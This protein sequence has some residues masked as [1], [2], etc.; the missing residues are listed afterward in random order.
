M[1][2]GGGAPE[3]E[4][5]HPVRLF[6]MRHAK[7]DQ[8]RLAEPGLKM[9]KD[10]AATFYEWADAVSLSPMT[11]P[12]EA[13][14]TPESKATAWALRTELQRLGRARSSHDSAPTT[15]KPKPSAAVTDLFPSA[16]LRQYGPYAADQTKRRS[17]A[18]HLESIGDPV[19]IVA[20]D[21]LI[22]GLAADLLS[23]R[24]VGRARFVMRHAELVCLVRTK[25]GRWQWE[26]SI[27][28]GDGAQEA[29]LREKIKSKMSIATALGGLIVALLTFL[30]T[31]VIGKSPN[32]WHWV[33][34]V[35]MI[36]SGVLYFSTLFLYD[37]LQMPAQFW[38]T[39][40]LPTRHTQARQVQRRWFGG[41]RLPSRPPSSTPRVMHAAMIH[42]W[43]RVFVPATVLVGLGL[44]AL[45]V[46][47]AT[48]GNA[49]AVC[50]EPHVALSLVAVGVLAALAWVGV[51]RPRLGTSD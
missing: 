1:V 51:Q 20:N 35:F 48:D 29:G 31:Q 27:A 2:T 23:P 34:V 33:A 5:G 38:P 40:A 46:G 3:T 50:V 13:A 42:I 19:L 11:L 26:W 22:S 18:Q 16:E 44:C 12:I 6:L 10:V 30:V 36:A 25:R 43:L 37:S 49:G 21:P 24:W 28:S 32:L 9:V 41:H 39:V 4:S 8:G 14:P 45:V 15:T 17:K 47:M 7:H